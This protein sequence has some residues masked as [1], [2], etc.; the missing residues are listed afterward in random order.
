MDHELAGT[1][2]TAHLISLMYELCDVQRSKCMQWLQVLGL[3]I[4]KLLTK[5]FGHKKNKELL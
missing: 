2:Y 1:L 4:F 3:L 5:M